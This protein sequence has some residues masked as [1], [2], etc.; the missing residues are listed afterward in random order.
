MTVHAAP[1]NFKKRDREMYRFV[2]A[3][4]RRERDFQSDIDGE[5]RGLKTV[6]YKNNPDMVTCELCIAVLPVAPK[7][8]K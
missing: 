5:L 2:T 1:T 3:C 8:T 7:E 4:G 6:D